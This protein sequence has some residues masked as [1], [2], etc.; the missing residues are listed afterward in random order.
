MS[1][2]DFLGIGAAR[3]GTTWLSAQLQQHPNVWM[4]RRKELHYFTRDPSY[5]S[6]SYLKE[7]GW[8][9]RLC[10]FD[11]DFKKFRYNLIKAMGRNIV[12]PNSQQLSWDLKYY[13]RKPGNM[14]YKSLFDVPGEKVTGE[15]TPAYGLLNDQGV[16]EVV[17]L[18]PDIKVFFILRD[19]IER[20]WST[21]RYHEKRY[22]K[23]LTDMSTQ[24]I[25][26]YLS[27]AAI[28]ER[29]NYEMVIERW[30]K[31][32]P[33]NQFLVLWYDQIVEE[34]NAIRK[35]LFDFVGVS[36]ELLSDITENKQVNASLDKTMPSEIREYLVSEYKASIESLARRYPNSYPER[37]LS[38]QAECINS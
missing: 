27:Y 7:G 26:D 35:S 22:G 4:P 31:I 20:A 28:T 12:S 25:K 23:K 30:E 14:W 17:E 38:Q 10:S 3:S 16:K 21:I 29:S 1:K 13:F 5:L 18:L 9:N 2:P 15:I 32:L 24:D 36:T 11:P 34:P 33:D 37:W 19:P 8:I 6:S